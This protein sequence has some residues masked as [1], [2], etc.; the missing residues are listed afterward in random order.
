MNILDP[1]VRAI[2]KEIKR[3]PD[4]HGLA[5]RAGA[6]AMGYRIKIVRNS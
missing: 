4:P 1:D 5:S 2:I 3:Y 6:R